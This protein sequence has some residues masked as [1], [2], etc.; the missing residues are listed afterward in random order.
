[1]EKETYLFYGSDEALELFET[2]RDRLM[3]AEC[4]DFMVYRQKESTVISNLEKEN[5]EHWHGPIVIDE[6]THT[7]LYLNLCKKARESFSRKKRD[8]NK[9]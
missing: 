7:L 2:S 6:N 8:Q 1:M 3:E 4:S 5:P 9:A